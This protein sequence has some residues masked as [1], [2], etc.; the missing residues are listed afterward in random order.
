MSHNCSLNYTTTHQN[1][2][3]EGGKKNFDYTFGFDTCWK[4]KLTIS[5]FIAHRR[6]WRKL[7]R[8]GRSSPA[9]DDKTLYEDIYHEN[10]HWKMK[11]T[12][13]QRKNNN[14]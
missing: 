10:G 4:I 9:R 1:G 3:N 8:S 7:T 14:N 5:P 6:G 11:C 13:F 2:E 12:L